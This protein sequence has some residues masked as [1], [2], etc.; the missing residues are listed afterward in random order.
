MTYEQAEFNADKM[1]QVIRETLQNS[2][3]ARLAYAGCEP[4]VQALIRCQLSHREKR[5]LGIVAKNEPDPLEMALRTRTR[6]RQEALF[7]QP[8]DAHARLKTRMAELYYDSLK[9]A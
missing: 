9:V 3:N 4:E 2:G 7:G 1:V 8:F 6:E 5:A